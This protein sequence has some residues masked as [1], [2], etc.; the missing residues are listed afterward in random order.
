[1]FLFIISYVPPGYKIAQ[2]IIILLFIEYRREYHFSKWP[3]L[4]LCLWHK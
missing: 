3:H 4:R 1:M 2:Y